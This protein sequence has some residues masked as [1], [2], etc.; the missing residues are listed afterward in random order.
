MSTRFELKLTPQP[1]QRRVELTERQQTV[2]TLICEGVTTKD[3]AAQL[4]ISV[5]TAEFHRARLLGLFG[6]KNTVQLV[7]IAIKHGLI[8]P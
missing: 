3:L 4:N 7:R 2:L 5:K 6:V 1:A 8:A